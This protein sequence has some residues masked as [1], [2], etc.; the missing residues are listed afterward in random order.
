MDEI[1]E[2]D[3]EI[4]EHLVQTRIARWRRSNIVEWS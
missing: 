4:E 2:G 1:E 3:E